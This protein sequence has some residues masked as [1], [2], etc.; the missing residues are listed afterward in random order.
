MLWLLAVQ[1]RI[2]LA[3]IFYTILEGLKDVHIT[4]YVIGRLFT[5]RCNKWRKL[6][7]SKKKKKK[8]GSKQR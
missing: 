2:K 3:I 7:M 4:K 6:D 5:N 8:C 1:Q